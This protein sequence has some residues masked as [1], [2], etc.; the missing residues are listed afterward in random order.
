MTFLI[1]CCVFLKRPIRTSEERENQLRNSGG[2]AIHALILNAWFLQHFP[3]AFNKRFFNA[4]KSVI[5][6]VI[7][8]NGLVSEN[9]ESNNLRSSALAPTN[10]VPQSLRNV[11]H[12]P[13]C[14]L[15]SSIAALSSLPPTRN[16]PSING[17][18]FKRELEFGKDLYFQRNC[19][20]F[21]YPNDEYLVRTL[22]Y[23]T[24][25]VLATMIRLKITGPL[26]FPLVENLSTPVRLTNQ[27]SKRRQCEVYL[28]LLSRQ[29]VAVPR[30][31]PSADL[32]ERSR[33]PPNLDART[34]RDRPDPFALERT[35]DPR[36]RNHGVKRSSSRPGAPGAHDSLVPNSNYGGPRPSFRARVPRTAGPSDR[37]DRGIYDPRRKPRPLFRATHR[38]SRG[39]PATIREFTSRARVTSIEIQRADAPTDE[40][41]S[42]RT[43]IVCFLFVYMYI[44]RRRLTK[45]TS[46]LVNK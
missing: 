19:S 10:F 22:Q 45:R 33:T 23:L 28:K 18:S 44:Y 3:P 25:W 41:Y 26:L 29:R 32:A 5:S 40:L 6:S 1:I 20:S 11:A 37:T 4:A 27:T 39:A 24:R 2:R 46:L 17:V 21:V 34:Q 16:K 13:R 14:L 30:L 8:H 42:R 31:S 35:S 36:A 43:F 9:A 12:T 7:G 38:A 15:S